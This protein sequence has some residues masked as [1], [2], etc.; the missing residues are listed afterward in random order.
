MG[1]TT[2][3]VGVAPP[4][5]FLTCGL[6]GGLPERRYLQRVARRQNMYRCC[7]S[8]LGHLLCELRSGSGILQQET[9]AESSRSECVVHRHGDAWAQEFGQF[10]CLPRVHYHL[11]IERGPNLQSVDCEEGEVDVRKTPRDLPQLRDQERIRPKADREVATLS[12]V[13][14]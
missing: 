10:R 2:L 1:S 4:S 13:R 8:T 12:D 3:G 9:I 5:L 7:W 14:V 11:A 6:C